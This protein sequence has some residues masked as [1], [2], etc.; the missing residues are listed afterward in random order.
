MCLTS[1][2]VPTLMISLALNFVE[3]WASAFTKS[4]LGCISSCIITA[5]SIILMIWKLTHSPFAVTISQSATQTQK[6]CLGCRVEALL[7][8]CNPNLPS[9]RLR[10]LSSFRELQWHHH[11]G[12][13][14]SADNDMSSITEMSGVWS[15]QEDHYHHYHGASW[16]LGNVYK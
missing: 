7:P 12:I 13:D 2:L 6:S 3:L 5:L 14:W 15:H 10:E 4:R 16:S 11:D 1:V 8:A 9:P